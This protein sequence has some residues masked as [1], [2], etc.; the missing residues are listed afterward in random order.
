MSAA[1]L[2]SDA[3]LARVRAYLFTYTVTVQRR[4]GT[5]VATGKP[6]HIEFPDPS[7]VLQPEGPEVAAVLTDM[8]D[9]DY[10]L[11]DVVTITSVDGQTTGLPQ[12]TKYSVGEVQRVSNPWPGTKVQLSGTNRKSTG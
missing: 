6:V 4:N 12:P 8:P 10:V 7:E 5:L 1:R 9:A 3:Q 2:L 11:G